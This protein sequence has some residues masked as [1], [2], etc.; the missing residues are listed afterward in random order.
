MLSQLAHLFHGRS[1]IQN[2]DDVK[3][4][5]DHVRRRMWLLYRLAG[6]NLL[7]TVCVVLW[8][9]VVRATGSGAGCGAHW[10]S[11]HGTLTPALASWETLIEWTHRGMSGALLLTVVLLAALS[12]LWCPRGHGAKTWAYVALALV[13]V[14]ALI[15]AALVLLELVGSNTSPVRAYVMGAHL[16]NTFVLLGAQYVHLWMLGSPGWRG[17]IPW[18]KLACSLW[19]AQFLLVLLTSCT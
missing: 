7:Y 14:E 16:M 18:K 12:W 2:P 10:P 9:A 8:G 13:I 6:A 1:Q 4:A 15:G 5:K 19:G 3:S 11:C 17:P